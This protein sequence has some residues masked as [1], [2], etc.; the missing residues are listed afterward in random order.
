MSIIH[1]ALKRRDEE[2][3][4]VQHEQVEE[5]EEHFFIEEQIPAWVPAVLAVGG[6]ALAAILTYLLTKPRDITVIVPPSE[7]NISSRQITA[8]YPQLNPVLGE[9]TNPNE[10]MR[11]VSSLPQTR[12]TPSSLQNTGLA[13]PIIQ[14]AQLRNGIPQPVEQ[15]PYIEDFRDI[16]VYHGTE[17][18]NPNELPP[19][20]VT[21]EMAEGRVESV[22]G[23]ARINGASAVPGGSLQVGSEISTDADGGTALA[24][25][26]ANIELAQSSNA[27]VTRL[28][29]QS[30]PNGEVSEEVTLHLVSGTAKALV[31]PGKGS[32]LISTKNVTATS[33]SGAFTVTTKE[34]GSVS[35]RGQGGTVR[36]VPTSNPD[37]SYILNGNENVEFRDGKW[38]KMNDE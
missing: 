37:A 25:D 30:K 38:H 28:E 3:S 35:V 14:D 34:D 8:E 32:V 18:S 29:R 15:T 33:S 17:L 12:L 4:A 22:F 9:Y 1:D 36:L 19:N 6:I 10:N 21:I 7:K 5:Q 27:R 23:A 16:P 24:F 11:D 26:H 20:A 2:M 13:A 31:R